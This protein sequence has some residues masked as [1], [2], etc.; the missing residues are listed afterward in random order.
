[1]DILRKIINKIAFAFA[2]FGFFLSL[3]CICMEQTYAVSSYCPDGSNFLINFAFYVLI[4]S[5]ICVLICPITRDYDGDKSVPVGNNGEVDDIA[6]SRWG[7]ISKF[8]F[9]VSLFEIFMLC[10]HVAQ[11]VGFTK[12]PEFFLSPNKER[13]IVDAITF[14]VFII[15]GIV[16]GTIAVHS[17]NKKNLS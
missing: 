9:Q 11:Y 7:R 5:L 13:L 3:A 12:Y 17:T 14:V 6:N 4:V 16:C 8:L 10:F 1:M 2:G 15:G